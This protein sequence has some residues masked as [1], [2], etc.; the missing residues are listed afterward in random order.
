[1]AAKSATKTKAKVGISKTTKARATPRKPPPAA[2]NAFVAGG[3]GSDTGTSGRSGGQTTMV[4]RVRSGETQ[5]RLTVYLPADL[6]RDV[7]VKLAMENRTFS[8]VA[9]ELFGAWAGGQ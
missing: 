7:R 5:Q 9:A 1:M 2:V 6:A 8:D 3:P 4:V